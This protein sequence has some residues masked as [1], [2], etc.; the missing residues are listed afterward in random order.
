MSE[1]LSKQQIYDR[2]KATSKD[3]YILEEMQRLG[4]WQS[5][6][7]PSLSEILIQQETTIQK[8]LNAL[9][10][11]DKKFQNKE[12]MLVEMRKARMKAAKERRVETL[13]KRE[14]LKIEK[15]Q[16]WK[17]T[18]E[19]EI[20]YLGDQ[21]SKGLNIQETNAALL[22]NYNLPVFEDVLALAQSM[23]IDLKALQY[24][25]YH[26]SVSKIHH[27]HTF[28]VSKKSGGKRKIS[29]PKPKLKEL[30]N[31]ILENILHKIP[32]TDEAHGFIKKRS[33]VTN[34]K[35]HLEKD[36]VINID[37]KDFFPTITHKRVKGLFHK[38]GYSEQIATIL[39]LLCTY[40]EVDEIDL[41]G[42]TYY[43]QS[44]ER[45][46]PQGAPTSPAIS[47]MIVY[48]MD[49]KISGLA[50]KLNFTYTRYADDMT[51]ST[52]NE[53][54]LNVSRLLYFIKKII[55]SEGF[56]IHPDKI[57][58]MRNGMQKK[59]TGVVVNKKLNVDRLQL[60]KFRAVLH[61]INQNG[62][63]DQQWGKA[64]HLIN[65]VEG[66]INYVAMVNP[67]KGAQFKKSLVAIISK[68]G[69]PEIEKPTPIE[70]EKLIV[71]PVLEEPKT[72][73]ED[74]KPGN[75]WNIF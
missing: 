20:I 49:K 39:S 24:L 9:L 11:Q 64:I 44:G 38:M 48:K 23:Q 4:F 30:Q 2:I 16:K 68:H 8:E 7:E 55:T 21:V 1:K 45:K 50:K 41:D 51:F 46:L 36:I 6:A 60:R 13:Q 63:K 15:A 28:E 59:V 26:R 22:D 17:L 14:Q 72:I 10:A 31:W 54:A 57:H 73:V 3:S 37:L 56:I 43:V 33:I 74:Q 32:H 40:S 19:K 61:N 27:Y 18:Q 5:G 42:V 58:I 70:K 67:E 66:Y 35:P 12:A 62:W 29:T 34:A 69:K 53:N 52:S 47:N 75:W 25:A 65:A 71:P